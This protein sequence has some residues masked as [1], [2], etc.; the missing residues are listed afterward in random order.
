MFSPCRSS[1]VDLPH[2]IHIP[3][4]SFASINPN[5]KFPIYCRNSATAATHSFCDFA[6]AHVAITQKHHNAIHFIFGEVFTLGSIHLSLLHDAM[7]NWCNESRRNLSSPRSMLRWLPEMRKAGLLFE[8]GYRI[9]SPEWENRR[10]VFVENQTIFHYSYAMSMDKLC[11]KPT[12][13]IAR[14]SC[15]QFWIGYSKCLEHEP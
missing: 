4:A 9:C 2:T 15:G 7:I 11:R 1:G 6:K 5:L 8:E 12:K 10:I 3:L 14:F 13:S